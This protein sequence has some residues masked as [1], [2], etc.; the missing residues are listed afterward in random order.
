MDFA[1]YYTNSHYINFGK[2]L[3]QGKKNTTSHMATKLLLTLPSGPLGSDCCQQQRKVKAPLYGQNVSR[4]TRKESLCIILEIE[5]LSSLEELWEVNI[6]PGHHSSQLL[7]N[8]RYFNTIRIQSL[9]QSISL[10]CH[11]IIS[12][13]M[14]WN[15]RV[16]RFVGKC[17]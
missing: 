2:I 16:L 9:I 10:A 3:Y 5:F 13:A 17:F 15:S 4:T 8:P 12:E 14:K 6:P 7:S 1:L 11:G